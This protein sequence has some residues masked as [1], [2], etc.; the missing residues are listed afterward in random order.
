MTQHIT[1]TLANI[2]ISNLLDT[3]MALQRECLHLLISDRVRMR[4]VEMRS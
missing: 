4:V 1:V 3:R 2:F